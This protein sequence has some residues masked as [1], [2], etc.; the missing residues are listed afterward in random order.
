MQ[1]LLRTYAELVVRHAWLVLLGALAVSGALASGMTRLVVDLDMEKQLP[2]DSPYVLVDRMIRKDFG[3]KNFVAIAIVPAAGTIW[4]K[5]VLELVHALTLDLLVAPGVIR[6]NVISL[7]SPYVRIPTTRDGTLVVDYLMQDVPA[8]ETAITALR[9]RY[10]GEPLFRGTVVSED[11][12][13]AMILADFYDD[14]I[15]LEINAVVRG[16]VAK[17]RSPKWR[18]AIA[19]E[20]MIQASESAVMQR[21]MWYFLG[22]IASIL[23][24]LYLAFGQ[25]QGMI[26]PSVTA[27]LSTACAMGFMGHTGIPLNTWTA[28][29]PLMV[30]TVAAGH[31]AQM[32]KR[33][34]EAFRQLGNRDAA[35]IESTSRIG[36][37]MM[38][39]GATAGSGF[40]ALSILGIPTLTHFGL[41]VSSGIFAAVA[42]EMTFMVAL[43]TLWPADR[44]QGAEGPLSSWLGYVLRPLEA[45]VV[46]RPWLVV[47][48]FAAI[49]LAA[50]AGFPR[51]STEFI[52]K[53]YRSTRTEVGRDALLF[54]KHF[55]STTTLTVL[56]EGPPGS[57]QS[58]E[59][60]RLTRGLT[61][62]MAEDPVVGRTSSIADIIQRTY[63]VFAPEEAAKGL[64]DDRELIA[65]LFFLAHSP[66]FERYVDRGYSRSVVLGFL[67][68]EDSGATRRVLD[69]LRAYLAQHPPNT[70]K[71]S[72][73]GG[74]GPT[75]LAFNE[76]TVRGKTL[77]IA[78]VLLVIFVIASILL[79]TA[80]GGAYMTAPLVMALIV[81]FGLFSWLGVP[82]DVVGASI[83]AISVGIGA[84]YAIYF[85]YRLREEYRSS[86][87][88]EAALHETMETSGRA[89]LFVALAVSAGFAVNIPADFLGLQRMGIF[90]PTTM[91]VSC[92]TA[93]TLLPALVLLLRPRFIF[94]AEPFVNE[95][96]N[97]LP[98]AK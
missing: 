28:A 98:A 59:A 64:R 57:M 44:R 93:L 74:V 23:L 19:G 89:V 80:L 17:Y 71:V 21:Q 24:V 85:L 54:E 51:L 11:E 15:A 81:D 53:H 18:I 43:R 16:V 50:A 88:I 2:A 55:P 94:A 76:H 45:A 84:D 49:A 32:L 56:L 67:N 48:T 8:D 97:V 12:R 38:A 27:L 29:A 13:A 68:E 95:S 25:L 91:I 41:G 37:V 65:Q 96:E 52:V 4:R 6:Q 22:T 63:E 87:D 72:L 69:R 78:V 86:G 10:Q 33:Y 79:R 3:G 83:A 35:V 39:A 62:A 46:R 60:L 73:A 66:A 7:S 31:S 75:I 58:P 70:I 36:V 1:H 92:L 5:D 42:L 20:P 9:E 47:G 77:N 14:T 90:V 40:A 82:F 30:V 34:Y 61:Q 26:I